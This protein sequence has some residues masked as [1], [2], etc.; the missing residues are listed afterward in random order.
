MKPQ[1]IMAADG[2]QHNA[3]LQAAGSRMDKSGSYK[4]LSTI[5]IV[6]AREAVPTKAV[7][8]WWNLMTPPNQKVCKLFAAGMEV[9]F[10]YESVVE[11][12]LNNPDLSTWKYILTLEHDNI[13]PPDGLLKLLERAE[14]HPE[15]DVI[16]GLYWTKGHGGVAQCWGNPNEV[17]I[18]FKPQKPRLDGGLLE[19]NGTG[20]GF[21]LYRI[22]MFKDKRLRRP[23]FKSAASREEGVFTQDLYFALDARKHGHRFAIDC[24][25]K[26]GHYDVA[27]D[28][29]W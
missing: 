5:I 3:D 6:P 19:V 14:A 24:S 18:N 8:A 17:P 4:D 11:A 23:W 12:I 15:F 26:I 1:I 27:N 13:P 28:Q 22:S 21:T 25:V 9:G 7:A 10:A 2:G 20:M 29:V 16:G